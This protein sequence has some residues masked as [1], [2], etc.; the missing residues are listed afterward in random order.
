[1]SNLSATNTAYWSHAISSWFEA[2]RSDPDEE[3]MLKYIREALPQIEGCWTRVKDKLKAR[4]SGGLSCA[5]QLFLAD[6]GYQDEPPTEAAKITWAI[7][8]LLHGWAYGCIVSGLPEGVRFEIEFTR[9]LPAWWP[10]EREG[11]AK[12]GHTDLVLRRDSDTAG[13]LPPE[14]GLNVLVDVKSSYSKGWRDYGTKDMTA[15]PDGFGYNSQLAVYSDG[16]ELYDATFLLAI[17]RDTPA[18]SK[19]RVRNVP[20][21]F[22]AEERE[23][24]I[25][26]FAQEGDPG[27][28][29]QDRWEG[30]GMFY[31][32][33]FCG[34]R[35][36]CEEL[37]V[38]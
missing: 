25:G 6:L 19:V 33:R 17:N 26:I 34:K 9:D 5:R 16:G 28:E 38:V 24:L 8:H 10:I 20:N 31:C 13:G 12:E 30:A 4:P 2:G 15:G 29:F 35:R 1:M 37:E 23:R 21:D 7:G 22:L 3:A 27:R 32:Q 36:G 11:F 14:C 18:S